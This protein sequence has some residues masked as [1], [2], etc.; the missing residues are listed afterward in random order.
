MYNTQ[1]LGVLPP[2]GWGVARVQGYFVWSKAVVDAM[3]GTNA[4]LEKALDRVFCGTFQHTNG[5]AYPCIP[6]DVDAAVFLESYY[7]SMATA[8]QD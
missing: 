8:D 6:Q 7:Q 4:G 2:K 1:D 5:K 3:R